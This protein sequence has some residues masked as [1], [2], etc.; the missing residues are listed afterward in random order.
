MTTDAN[1]AA[2]VG[3]AGGVG[4]TRIAVELGATLARAG[5]DVALLDAAYATQGLASHVEGRLD[6]D[7]TALVTGA[8]ADLEAGLAAFD[9]DAPG[10][11]ACCPAHAPFERVAR[12]KTPE[13]ARALERLLDRAAADFEYALVDVP[14]VAANQSVAAVTAADRTAL[15]TRPTA[16]GVDALQR[17]RGRLADLGAAPTCTV[18]NRADEATDADRAVP[19]SDR[20]GVPSEPACAGGDDPM[21]P[22]VAAL[23]E[24]LF[25]ADLDLS[26][27]RGLLGSRL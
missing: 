5:R 11:L 3:A 27:S 17:A 21:A 9:L 19:E 12:A 13:A 6:P 25:D 10:T 20:T 4:A 8:D 2:V 14:P 23:A 24:T 22:A 7:V 1:T 15:V 16:R 26:F 18:A